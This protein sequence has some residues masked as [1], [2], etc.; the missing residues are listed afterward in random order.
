[1]IRLMSLMPL[2]HLPTMIPPSAI[3]SIHLH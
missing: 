2:N 3:L 1:V